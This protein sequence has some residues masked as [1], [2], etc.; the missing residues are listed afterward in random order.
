MGARATASIG[1]LIEW[2]RNAS[3]KWAY[4]AFFE[5]KKAGIVGEEWQAQNDIVCQGYYEAFFEAENDDIAFQNRY[6]WEVSEE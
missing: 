4:N 2:C 1:Y 5:A 3:L 6:F